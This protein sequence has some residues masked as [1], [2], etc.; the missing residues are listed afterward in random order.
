MVPA[1][2]R[3]QYHP[4]EENVPLSAAVREAIEAHGSTSLH[5]D[6]F[7]LYDHVSPDAIDA[8]FRDADEV[9]V[10]LQFRLTNVTVSVWSDDAIDIR[11]TDVLDERLGR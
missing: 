9:D 10:V 11:V 2:E 8:L 7:D 1:T 5:A 3:R 4:G 6:E